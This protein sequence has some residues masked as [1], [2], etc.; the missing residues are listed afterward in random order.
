M[1]FKR[2]TLLVNSPLFRESNQSYDENV[3]PPMG[4]AYIASNLK[5]AGISC[6]L[7]DAVYNKMGVE[8]ICQYFSKTIPSFIGINIFT[9]NMHLVKEIVEKCQIETTFIIGG[10]AAKFLY[11]V[12][13]IYGFP[14]ETK[15]DMVQTNDFLRENNNCDIKITHDDELSDVTG[16]SLSCD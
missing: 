1:D 9:A 16:R 12:Y 13:F 14:G 4:L 10:Q 8:E 3:I 2:N 6:N 11:K 5:D 7:L 15:D